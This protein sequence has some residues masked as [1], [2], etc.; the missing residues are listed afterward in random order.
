M[1]AV[2][3]RLGSIVAVTALA[4][5]SGCY[6]RYVPRDP[7]LPCHVGAWA[8]DRIEPEGVACSGQRAAA[9]DGECQA[10]AFGVLTEDGGVWVVFV[11]TDGSGNRGAVNLLPRGTNRWSI[12]GDELRIHHDEGFPSWAIGQSFRAPLHGCSAT[13]FDGL[14][15]P[16][17]IL[18][19]EGW[20]HSS[21][22]RVDAES[23][24]Q[25]LEVL[26]TLDP[27]GGISVTWWPG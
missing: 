6:E 7:D 4:L 5:T 27:E 24:R 16:Y 2:G 15:E 17:D 12:D 25:I 11:G 14:G 19:G 9:F 18:F 20:S 10:H 22:P 1:C 26:P 3:E 23:E 21:C 13:R 8:C